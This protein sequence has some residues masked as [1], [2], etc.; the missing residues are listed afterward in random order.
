M[1]AVVK[2]KHVFGASSIKTDFITWRAKF[3]YVTLLLLWGYAFFPTL[4]LMFESAQSIFNQHCLLAAP[5]FLG[6]VLAKRSTFMRIAP[7]VS[8]LGL[9]LLFLLSAVWVFAESKEMYLLQQVCVLALVP[10]I[11]M[12]AFGYKISKM[13]IFPLSYVFLLLPIGHLIIPNIQDVLLTSLVKIF[14]LSDLPVYWDHQS[15]RTVHSELNLAV[16]GYGLTFLFAF[17]AIG[18]IYAYCI[19]INFVRRLV[20]AMMFVLFP[21][22]AIFLGAY[23]F[24]RY[25]LI[26][27][28]LVLE[29]TQLAYY[30]WGLIA[31]GLL[32]SVIFGLFLKQSKPYYDTLTGVDWQSSWKHTDFQWLRPTIIAAT[33]FAIVP[34][35][36]KYTDELEQSW[37][38]LLQV[39]G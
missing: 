11:F 23:I 15:I 25:Q 31:L 18:F 39:F 29:P 7:S 34:W 35:M 37:Q 13:F 12:L 10:A 3:S 4:K 26:I 38:L 5:L 16:F 22:A 32:A 21:I 20:V 14:A 19:V 2:S 33:V 17:L 6:L 28:N 36:P 8:Q 27:G 30:G 1:A 9:L 24:L